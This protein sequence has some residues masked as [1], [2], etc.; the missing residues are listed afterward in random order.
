MFSSVRHYVVPGFQLE[1]DLNH[2][3]RYS[4]NYDSLV[5]VP[6]G[7]LTARGK[8]S[9]GNFYGSSQPLLFAYH[10]LRTKKNSESE[11]FKGG[12][13]IPADAA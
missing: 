9:G 4:G 6:A 10:H 2:Q 12:I 13:Y 11:Q 5:T 8:N 3:G 7:V 1:Q